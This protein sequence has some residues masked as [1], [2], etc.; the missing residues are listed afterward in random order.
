MNET[1]TAPLTWHNATRRLDE[2][3]GWEPNPRYITRQQAARLE[4]SLAEFGQVQTIA[5]EPDNTIVDGH[6]RAHV[7]AAARKFGPAYEIDVR[8]ASRKLTVVERQALVLAL[9]GGASGAWDWDKIANTWDFEVARTWGFDTRQ[10]T[11]WDSDAANLALYIRA[12]QT[13][14]KAA[15]ENPFG[16]FE[17]V[18][19][20]PDFVAFKF[21]RYAGQVAKAVYES[22]IAAYQRHQ[23][24]S[25]E[26]ML[27]DVLRSWLDV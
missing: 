27:D 12:E 1:D 21:G 5:I 4:R 23:D 25:G 8:V 16:S 10:I 20:N 11:Q 17:D 24:E 14:A 15:E 26:A 3:V 19:I 22:F 9:H 6:Q 2:L 13:L 18:E 7:W